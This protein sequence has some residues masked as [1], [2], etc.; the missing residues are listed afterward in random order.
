M[1][2]GRRQEGTELGVIFH[3]T[4]PVVAPAGISERTRNQ[5]LV[6][7]LRPSKKRRLPDRDSMVRLRRGSSGA[8]EKTGPSASRAARVTDPS[9]T[10]GPLHCRE[11]APPS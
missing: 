5:P 9:L 4:A 11:K 8:A 7:V 3:R 2:G 6:S 1:T 10:Q